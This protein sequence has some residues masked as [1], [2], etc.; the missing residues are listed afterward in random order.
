MTNKDEISKVWDEAAEAWSDFVRTGKDYYR[1][2]LNNP[3]TFELIGNIRGKRVLDLACGEGYNTRILAK[4]GAKV[5]AVDF[6]PATIEIARQK[7]AEENL[8]IIY[9]VRDASDLRDLPSDHFDLVTCFMSLQDIEHLGKAVSEAARVLR[10]KG[11]FIFSIPHPCFERIVK[12]SKGWRNSSGIRFGE[13]EYTGRPEIVSAQEDYF[14]SVKYEVLWTMERLGK[15][16]KTISFHRTLTE[17]F[18]AIYEAGLMVQR[19]VEPRPIAEGIAK[20]QP[21]E[22]HF[23]TP[24]SIVI[25][26]IKPKTEG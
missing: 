10:P 23:K 3:A 24:Q 13:N 4:K 6:S 22:K 11:R 8:G 25:E 16:F 15:P 17:N 9:L 20:H 26:V 19:L 21:M 18:Q 12:D 7:K 5:T 14:D 1:E 2:Y